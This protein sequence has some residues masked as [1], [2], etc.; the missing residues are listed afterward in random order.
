MARSSPE[1]VARLQ[2]HYLERIESQALRTELELESGARRVG[3]EALEEKARAERKLIDF[4]RLT[5][6]VLDPGHP[7]I[8][9]WAVEAICEHLQAVADRQIRKLLITVPPGF[10]K[11]KTGDVY[12]PA[13]MWGP[14]NRPEARFLSASYAEHLTI[15]NNRDCRNLLKSDVYQSLWGD[16]FKFAGDQDAKKRFDNDH[17]G[18]KIATHVG[19]A[20]GDRGDFL[21][22]DDAHNVQE[23]ESDAV[24]ESTLTWFTETW[25]TRFFDA[26]SAYLVWMQRVHHRDV[27]GLIIEKELGFVHLNLPM[28]FEVERR[29]KTV[30]GFEDPRKEEHELLAPE[31]MDAAFLAEKKKDLAA[32]GGPYAYAA[33]YQQRPVPREGGMFQAGKAVVVKEAPARVLARVRGYDLAASKAKGSPWTVGAKLSLVVNPGRKILIYVEDVRRIQGLTHDVDA[34]ILECAEGDGGSVTHDF[35]QDPGQAGKAQIASIAAL[36]SGHRMIS[37]P[38]TGDKEVRAGPFASQWNSGNVRLV[39]GKWNDAFT[40]ELEMFPRGDFKDQV[41]ACSRAYARLLVKLKASGPIVG[42]VVVTA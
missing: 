41:D 22:L 29:C 21:N 42:P 35:P 7:F 38:E 34:M 30:I 26:T 25:L 4:V 1:F 6:S 20:T 32:H 36:L 11:S 27:A 39:E 23:G 9:G 17:R 15:R 12:F 10:G 13:W 28:E 5:W 18:Y 16:R 3:P 24:R 8:G 40:R 31:R 19:G 37:S 33:Q 14:R 2:R